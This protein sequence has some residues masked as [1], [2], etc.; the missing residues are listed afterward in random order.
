M[1][2]K[3]SEKKTVILIPSSSKNCNYKGLKSSALIGILYK[4]LLNFDVSKYTFLIGFDNDDI[5]FTN[6]KKSIENKLPNNFYLYYL[7]NY[8]KSYVCI[9]NQLANIAINNYQADYLFVIADDLIFYDFTFIDKFIEYLSDKKLGLGY[10]I[11][12]SCRKDICTH[13]FVTSNHVKYLGYFYPNYI[14][15]WY[16]DTWI[17]KL[18]QNFNLVC[19]TESFVLENKILEKRYDV[20]NIDQEKFDELVKDAEII[21]KNELDK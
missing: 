10:S 13:P 11:D 18:Y 12:K 14:K 21:L 7:D 8:D 19:K 15:N 6:F 3:L 20:Y 9:V 16:C 17:T 5:F 4:S 2:N 1:N